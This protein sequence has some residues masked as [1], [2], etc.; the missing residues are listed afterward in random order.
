QASVTTE[1]IAM[2][3]ADLNDR[4]CDASVAIALVIPGGKVDFILLDEPTANLDEERKKSLVKVISQLN[5]Q[6]GASPLKQIIVITHD[7]E[8]FDDAD[9]NE[10]YRFEKTSNGSSVSRE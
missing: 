5:P 3:K 2:G 9:V 8:I 4:A 1:E 10:V 6:S 7:R